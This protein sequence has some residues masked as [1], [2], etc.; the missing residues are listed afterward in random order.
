MDSLK[1]TS[2]VLKLFWNDTENDKIYKYYLLN[3][4]I[5]LLDEGNHNI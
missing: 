5:S 3:L 4:L 2:I 1:T